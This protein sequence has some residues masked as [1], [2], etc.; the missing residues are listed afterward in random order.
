MQGGREYY[1][2]P[3]SGLVF[4]FILFSDV[5][6]KKNHSSKNQTQRDEAS[7]AKKIKETSK[8]SKKNNEH[9]DGHKI[10]LD[11]RVDDF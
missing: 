11:L 6:E 10:S 1:T 9:A 5:C 2:L 4:F 8:G 7:T 3:V